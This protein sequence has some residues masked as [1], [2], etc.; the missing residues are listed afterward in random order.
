MQCLS[1]FVSIWSILVN[2][3]H[4]CYADQSPRRFFFTCLFEK[5]HVFVILCVFLVNI[6]SILVNIRT[7]SRDTNNKS[8]SIS[9]PPTPK[10]YQ[11]RLI[12]K[13]CRKHVKSCPRSSPR[14]PDDPRPTQKRQKA[15]PAQHG[16]HTKTIPRHVHTIREQSA[17]SNAQ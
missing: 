6:W 9:H 8:H 15:V 13:T 14:E 16:A 3:T 10:E 2:P 5:R 4:V 1:I 7:Y 11:P 12:S 17:E